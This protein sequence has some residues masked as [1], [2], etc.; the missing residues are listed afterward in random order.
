MAIHKKAK[1]ILENDYS[2][3]EVQQFIN[4]SLN[5]ATTATSMW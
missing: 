1:D 4:I 3:E 5:S 2:K